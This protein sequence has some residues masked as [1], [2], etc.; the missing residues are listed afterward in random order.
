MMEA[1]EIAELF[2]AIDGELL[3]ELDADIAERGV[4]EPITIYE[5]KVLDGV[6]RYMLGTMHGKHVPSRPLPEGADP[7]AYCIARNLRRRHLSA[8]QRAII[9]EALAN[10]RRPGR[11]G[12]RTARTRKEAAEEVGGCSER[13]VARAR[14]VRKDCDDDVVRA[15]RD[16][17]VTLSDAE[18]VRGQSPERQR[19]A[20]SQVKNG[21][22]KSLI[23]AMERAEEDAQKKKARAQ[24]SNGAAP[25]GT[26]AQDAG[27]DDATA[28]PAMGRV[29]RAREVLGHIDTDAASS[30]RVNAT[31]AARHWCAP[32]DTPEVWGETAWL[33][34]D[35]IDPDADAESAERVLDALEEGAV[36]KVLI[37]TYGALSRPWAK[38]ALARCERIAIGGGSD[39]PV[40]ILLGAGADTAA[41]ER[42]Y[43]PDTVVFQRAGAQAPK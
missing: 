9:A 27:D 43:A 7:I 28:M 2:P 31:V 13:A 18:R 38:R 33:R 25:A 37:E 41:F 22:A 5:G 16:G 34:A 24:K 11:K 19:A 29:H 4:E 10:H 39:A 3:R 30:A 42:A 36:E 20:V 6:H 17:Q 26:P 32:G 12:E 1:H 23:E 14:T 21:Q 35:D 8:S 40:A 15:V